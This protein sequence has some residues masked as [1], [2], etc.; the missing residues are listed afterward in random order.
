[1]L[2]NI[3]KAALKPLSSLIEQKAMSL[4]DERIG[5]IFGAIPTASGVLVTGNSAMHVP[6]VLQAVRLISETLGSLP[7]K[8]YREAGDSKEAAKVHPAHK[9]THSRANEWT[10]AGQLRIDLTVDAL[11]HGAGYA[12]VVRTS[13][14]RPLELHRLD[15][16]KVQ[17]QCEDDGEAKRAG[18]TLDAQ[19]LASIREK[20]T[21]TQQLDATN[22]QV[23]TSSEGLRNAQQ[24]FAES[25]TS[26]LSGLLTGTQTLNGALQN[27]LS[28][29]IDATLQAA[30]LGKGPL[31]G[32]FG[33]TGTG[34]LGAIFGFA[35]G[36]Y[37]G[38]GGKYQAAGVVHRG[39]YV[40]SKEATRRAGVANLDAL[41]SS[42]KGYAAGGYVGS[43][44][45]IRKP[46]LKA[47]NGNAAS[48]SPVNI[49]TNV[50]VNASGGTPEQNSDLAGKVGKQIERQM[51][52]VV[53][54]ELRRQS[55]PGN[56]GNTRSR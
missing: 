26:S 9:I 52:S 12:Q 3:K 48:A 27:L 47:A 42:L 5:E 51:R 21:L 44:P 30:L 22:Q 20:I 53:A 37:T 36:G 49:N 23:A 29:L 35:D 50:T 54:D 15:P 8:L 13:D 41:H 33:G 56:F 10:S 28:S 46:D 55:R 2:E 32:L 25:F 16:S 17:R 40:L 1:M 38:D 7:C 11:L 19:E 43:A 34:L 18:I 14:D 24:Y 45:A 39:E 6:A 4:V 31:A